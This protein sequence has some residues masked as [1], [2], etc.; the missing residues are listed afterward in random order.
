[1][2]AEDE[3]AFRE[4]FAGRA[5]S[6]RRTAYLLCGDWHRAEDLVQTAFVKLYASWAKVRE[7]EALDSYL[8]TVLVRAYVDETRRPSRRERLF[9]DVPDY[10]VAESGGLGD[11]ME[12]AAALRQVP[13]RQRACLVLRFYDDLSVTETA[14]ALGCAEGTVKSQTAKGLGTLRALLGSHSPLPL[15]L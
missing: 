1:M 13:P 9:G 11:R 15:E 14:A 5:R 10:A 12:L 4:L 7:R 3:A 8:R 2:R 6:L